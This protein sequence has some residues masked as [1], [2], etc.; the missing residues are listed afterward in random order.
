MNIFSQFLR[1]GVLTSLSLALCFVAFAPRVRAEEPERPMKVY[2]DGLKTVKD[3]ATLHHAEMSGCAYQGHT[4]KNVDFSWAHMREAALYDMTFINCNF[5]KADM[6]GLYCS[7]NTRFIDCNFTNAKITGAVNL[8]LTPDS[9]RQTDD[10]QRKKLE[11]TT[12]LLIVNPD[13]QLDLSGFTIYKSDV[14]RYPQGR[15]E[16]KLTDARL[17]D[18]SCA[19]SELL[20]SRSFKERSLYGIHIHSEDYSNVDFSNFVIFNC[21]FD[22]AVPKT[23]IDSPR[24]VDPKFDGANFSN[25][26]V[27][28]CWFFGNISFEQLK[29]TWN[30]QNGR[31]DWGVVPDNLQ[32]QIDAALKREGREPIKPSYPSDQICN[33]PF[34]RQANTF[35]P[36]DYTPLYHNSPE[37]IE[38]LMKARK[39]ALLA[40]T[41]AWIAKLEAK[42]PSE[43]ATETK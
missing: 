41:E 15:L 31:Y 36:K 4:V 11:Y 14:M 20:D 10:F 19:Y 28:N 34:S 12:I 25:A 29:S 33:R 40:D 43:N 7:G 26:V 3:G 17:F 16:L 24:V 32:R 5:Y 27:I 23:P 22:A 42:A 37:E 8:P 38:Q 18:T 39:E 35:E 9:F 1:N 13:Y 6:Q 21:C 2:A 30:Y